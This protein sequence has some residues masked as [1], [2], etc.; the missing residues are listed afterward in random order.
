MLCR[1]QQR[2]VFSASSAQANL[3]FHLASCSGELFDA[4]IHLSWGDVAVN[5]YQNPQVIRVRLCQSKTD[6]F[7]NGVEVIVG[8]TRDDLCPVAAV[9]AFMVRRGRAPGPFFV[10]P[11]GTPLTKAKFV[12]IMRS[13]VRC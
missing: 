4:S 12:G 13:A 11:D 3:Q 1:G 7:G 6:Q 9:A 10:F 5:D 2:C 8:K